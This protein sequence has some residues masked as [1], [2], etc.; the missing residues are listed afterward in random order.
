MRMTAGEIITEARTGW[1]EPTADFITASEALRWVNLAQADFVRRT[2]CLRYYAPYSTVSEQQEYPLPP[3]AAIVEVLWILCEGK[4]LV[5]T[6]LPE[7]DAYNR[8]WRY[9]AGGSIGEPLFYYISRV[10][11]AQLGLFPC[12]D[13]AYAINLYYVQSAPLIVSTEDYPE[14]DDSYH[15]I[16][17]Y[18]VEARGHRK[19]RDYDAATATLNMYL[20][21]VEDARKQL[22]TLAPERMMVM[23]GPEYRLPNRRLGLP[24]LP[25]H[26]GYER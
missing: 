20:A 13:G 7:L 24:R 25:D 23:S 15:D 9:A 14:I 1:N 10:D 26:Y 19:N 12:P 8:S 3:D 11:D 6:T 18:F 16:L 21:A 17:E 5:P 2:K 22:A 4:P